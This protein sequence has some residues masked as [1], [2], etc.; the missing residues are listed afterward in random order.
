M[1]WKERIL[2][3][4]LGPV[5]KAALRPVGIMRQPQSE[6]DSDRTGVGCTS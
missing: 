5:L 4:V 3:P 6:R 2:F 1:N